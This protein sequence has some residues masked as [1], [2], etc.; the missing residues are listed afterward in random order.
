MEERDFYFTHDLTQQE[1]ITELGCWPREG[2]NRGPLLV[3]I[4]ITQDSNAS[5]NS[6]LRTGHIIIWE[7]N[8]GDG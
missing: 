8:G 3:Y 6:C 1:A 7:V 4:V 5:Q 2:Q